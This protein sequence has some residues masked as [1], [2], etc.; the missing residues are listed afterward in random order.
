MAPKLQGSENEKAVE[1]TP[2]T[3]EQAPTIAQDKAGET[4]E[5]PKKE[6]STPTDETGGEPVKD[7]GETPVKKEESDTDAAST[8]D[9]ESGDE[10]DKPK[11]T[12]TEEDVDAL[13]QQEGFTCCG[14]TLQA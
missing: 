9:E 2:T 7:A 3:P 5:S 12:E 13:V 6:E 1:E 4:V 14:I 8:E 10:E 11:V